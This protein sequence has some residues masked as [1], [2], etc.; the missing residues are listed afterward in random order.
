MPI[1]VLRLGNIRV[2]RVS[3]L[4]A[5]LRRRRDAVQSARRGVVDFRTNARRDLLTS[6]RGVV[7]RTNSRLA[8]PTSGVF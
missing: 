1:G 7:G 2:V 3:S 5:I 8:S 4:L 6:V